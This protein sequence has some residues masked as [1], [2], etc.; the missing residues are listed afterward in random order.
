MYEVTRF[1]ITCTYVKW[2]RTYMYVF[3]ALVLQPFSEQTDVR[4]LNS[5]SITICSY[6]SSRFNRH[7]SDLPAICGSKISERELLPVTK[8][9]HLSRLH[10]TQD[11]YVYVMIT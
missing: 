6:F 1:A 8:T 9:S 10:A 4:V 5:T 3:G 11:T 2:H 7:V